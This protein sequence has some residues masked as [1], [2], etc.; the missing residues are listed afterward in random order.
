MIQLNDFLLQYYPETLEVYKRLTTPNYFECGVEYY[1]QQSGCGGS[2]KNYKKLLFK[3]ATIFKDTK[4][5][6]LTDI[7]E[8][9]YSYIITEQEAPFKLKRVNEDVEYKNNIIDDNTQKYIVANNTEYSIRQM[10]FRDYYTKKLKMRLFIYDL[11]NKNVF[12]EYYNYAIGGTKGS[13]LCYYPNYKNDRRNYD[14]KFNIP[15]RKMKEIVF[16]NSN[17]KIK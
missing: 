9:Q 1:P 3:N 2:G 5:F 14:I 10:Y 12:W 4:H 6:H 16:G 7:K 15:V 8:P 13:I 17:I 11:N